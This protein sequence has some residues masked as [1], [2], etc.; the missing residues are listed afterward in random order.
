MNTARE[1]SARL[2]VLLGKEHHAMAEFLVALADF[3]QRRAWVELGHNSLFSYLRRDLH[4]SAGAAQHRKTA[5]ELVQRFP[6]VLAALRE[7]KLCL[8]SVTSLAKVVSPENVSE[9]LPRF[10]GLS[11]REAEAL[12]VSIHPVED[13]PLREVVTPVRLPANEAAAAL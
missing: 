12:A 1:L 5:A 6:E 4:L 9:L 11:A 8:S 13:P 10:F 3:D 2:A 7:G